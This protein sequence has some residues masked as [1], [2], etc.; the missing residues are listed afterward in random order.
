MAIEPIA[1]GIVESMCVNGQPIEQTY[2]LLDGPCHENHAGFERKL[3]G[4]D[5]E[6]VRTSSLK[7]GATV[8]NWRTWT[9]LSRGEISEV[10][11]ELGVEIPFGC[12]LENIT[13]SGIPNF[14]KLAPTTRLVFPFREKMLYGE[15]AILAVWEENGPCKHVGKRLADHHSNFDLM[16]TFVAAA[17]GKRGVMGIVVAPGLIEV[18]DE[19]LVYPPARAPA[20]PNSVSHLDSAGVRDAVSLAD[21]Q[22][23]QVSDP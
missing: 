5:S 17:H 13:F 20:R 22:L 8:F 2:F 18:G 23:T 14:S 9:G 15:Q 7:K 12:L 19:V 10:E 3:S 21:T 1:R 6:Y 4:H 11:Q 16:T